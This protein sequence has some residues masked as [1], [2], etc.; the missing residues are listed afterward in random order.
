MF[1]MIPKDMPTP[2]VRYPG[3]TGSVAALDFGKT[4]EIGVGAAAG[5]EEGDSGFGCICR[6][7]SGLQWIAKEQF[8]AAC[9]ASGIRRIGKD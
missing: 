8:H 2:T 5:N 4:A 9:R 6:G 3:V 1:G 7:T